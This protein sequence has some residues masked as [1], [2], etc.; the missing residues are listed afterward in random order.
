MNK[1][2]ILVRG[3]I[4][5]TERWFPVEFHTY[6]GGEIR[7]GH[8]PNFGTS[9]VVDVGA[10]LRDANTIEAFFHVAEAL[11][12]RGN[13][14]RLTIP[15]LPYARQDRAK[16]FLDG[17]EVL[18][19]KLFANRVN[20]LQAL[21]V[22]LFD[23]HSDV[24]RALFDRAI[25]IEREECM[26]RSGVILTTKD[27]LI[28][29]DAGALKATYQIAKKKSNQVLVA[30]KQRDMESGKIT[31]TSVHN[32]EQAHGKN[33]WILD[34]LIDGGYTFIQ[35]AQA[36]K[37]QGVIADTL[38]LYTTH[39]IYSKGLDDLMKN[40]NRVKALYS[41]DAGSEY[42]FTSGLFN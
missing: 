10:I 40:F 23:P 3:N 11:K 25:I 36:L 42:E 6:P 16:A 9:G 39:G 27:V 32:A 34:D 26:N 8:I 38:N 20:A 21:S 5:P 31:G 2:V 33:V 4:T 22:K 13:T 17:N 1:N 14:I 15:Y 35:I 29:P 7:L 12:F 18:G 41:F 37:N 30:E 28:A 19:L 24:T